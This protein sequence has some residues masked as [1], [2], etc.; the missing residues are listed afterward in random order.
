MTRRVAS[1]ISPP[2]ADCPMA[3]PSAKLCSPM[4]TAISSASRR[5]G[6]PGRQARARGGE[7]DDVR[8]A[9]AEVGRRGRP[10]RA[11]G[12]PPIHRSYADQRQ[13]A[14]GQA[15]R[16][17]HAVSDRAR[18]DRP[19]R[20]GF[21]PA[22]RR[23]VPMLPRARPRRG[24]AATPTATAFSSARRL[25]A[26]RR[27]RPIGNPSRI[28]TPA[29]AP[30]TNVGPSPMNVSLN[31]TARTPQVRCASPGRQ[32]G[33]EGRPPGPTRTVTDA[34]TRQSRGFGLRGCPETSHGGGGGI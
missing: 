14:D 4:P 22:R 28:V 10:A 9:G 8:G 19:G 7:L 34:R 5:A 18:P 31:S 23:S 24:R 1:A 26:G 13:Q 2:A 20:R 21:R 6:R 12:E 17:Q 30:R 29:I 3:S 27:T 33:R 11:G 15:A 16:E 32:G 25:G